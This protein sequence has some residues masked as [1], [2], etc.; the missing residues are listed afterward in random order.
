MADFPRL[1]TGAVLQY[2]AERTL[3]FP[4]AK[5]RFINGREQRFRSS[6]G[7][8]RN[9]VIRLELLDEAELSTIEQFFQDQQGKFGRF[10]FRDPADG[11]EYPDCSIE[12]SELQVQH[13]S[14]MTGSTVLVIRQNQ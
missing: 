13:D 10:T 3:R 1:K 4:T 12:Q 9:W 14:E 11:Q 5:F 8:I 6:A 2:P 7:V